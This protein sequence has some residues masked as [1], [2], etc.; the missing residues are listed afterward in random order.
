MVTQ[1]ITYPYDLAVVEETDVE[2]EFE[3]TGDEGTVPVLE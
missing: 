2:V 1:A 3:A